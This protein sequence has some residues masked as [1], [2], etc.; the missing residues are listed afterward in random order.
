MQLH[1]TSTWVN[2]HES[3]FELR[4]R[5]AREEARA[6][7]RKYWLLGYD[8]AAALRLIDDL[9]HVLRTMHLVAIETD[10]WYVA[11]HYPNIR[12]EDAQEHK[13]HYKLQSKFKLHPAVI[14]KAKDDL[15]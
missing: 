15:V 10:A 1:T 6:K 2:P 11:R 7:Q 14:A 3:D 9:K 4:L 13:W 12:M 8:G 5:H